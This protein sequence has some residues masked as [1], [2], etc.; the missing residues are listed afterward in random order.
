M[1]GIGTD[2][3][4]ISRIQ[5]AIERHQKKESNTFLNRLFTPQEQA[6][7]LG[8]SLPAI[9]FAARFA[10][11]EAVSKALGCGI[12][13]ELSWLDIE[14]AKSPSGKPFVRLSESAKKQHSTKGQFELSI[15]HCESYAVA[16]V[17]HLD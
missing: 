17:I 15:S 7:C 3:I 16:F 6:Y 5:Q 4:E 11:K 1:L 9:P 13:K 12:G 8:F 10:A 14:I 2:I